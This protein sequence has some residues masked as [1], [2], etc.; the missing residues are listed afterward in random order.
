MT[1]FEA[2]LGSEGTTTTD[3]TCRDDGRKQVL[4]DVIAVC[5]VK[6]VGYSS[7]Q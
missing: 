1:L 5:H 4:S 6:D 7:Y 2:V 3:E